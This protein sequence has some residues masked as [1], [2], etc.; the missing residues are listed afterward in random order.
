RRL[1]EEGLKALPYPVL[2]ELSPLEESLLPE[3]KE[4]LASLFALEAFGPGRVRLLAAPSFL[5]PY[6]LLL[7]EIFRE[8]LRGEGK[9]LT[10]LLA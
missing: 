7:P 9:S 5:H 1:K 2:V 10:E 8:A 6:P 4:V 3:R